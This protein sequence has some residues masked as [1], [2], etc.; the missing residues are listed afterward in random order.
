MDKVRTVSDTKRDFYAHHSRPI[1]SIYRRIVEELMVEMH[2]LSVNA[3]FSSD[4]FY[5][6][7]V[8]TS[9]DRFMQGYRPEKDKDSIFSALCQ[10]VSGD[11]QEYR[12]DAQSV[13]SLGRL[14]STEELISW[15]GSPTPAEGEE[16]LA[17]A[18]E[19][20]A[21][22][23]NF[24][25]SRLFGIGLYTLIETIAPEAVKDEKQRNQVLDKLAETLHFS[26]EKLK[27]DLEL[28]RGNLE[29]MEQLLIVLKDSLEADRKKREQ[30]TQAKEQAS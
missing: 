21:N 8:V 24:K 16:K 6:L 28:Y 9:F 23:P 5:R 12:Q 26:N 4:P 18:V 3:E 30:R 22:N 15:F 14:S 19:A 7:G 10:S 2:L 1:N 27:K 29:K 20:I 13:L 11:P 17:E 25:Y